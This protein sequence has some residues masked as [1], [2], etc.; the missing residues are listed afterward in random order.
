MFVVE[1]SD[2]SS[3]L[4]KLN[5]QSDRIKADP[6]SVLVSVLVEVVFMFLVFVF[7]VV[8]LSLCYL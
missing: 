5:L 1:R 3:C 4:F 8:S 6:V 7:V 2:L